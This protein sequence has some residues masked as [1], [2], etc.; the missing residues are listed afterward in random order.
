V[1][2]DPVLAS[3]D[4]GYVIDVLP[5]DPSFERFGASVT[6]CV[7]SALRGE[8]AQFGSA[9]AVVLCDDAEIADYHERF[10]RVPGPTDVISW[11]ADAPL[12]DVMVSCET[13]RR[14]AA[15]YG[16]SWEREVCVLA[17]H[18]TLHLLG[19][20]DLSPTERHAMQVRVDSIVDG[21][22]KVTGD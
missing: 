21:C 6:R 22:L 13:A 14:Q 1:S 15:T 4:T 7:E 19:W 16:N 18:G 9:L 2:A 10:M 3:A 12:G 8:N 11:P 20:D 17:V 5:S